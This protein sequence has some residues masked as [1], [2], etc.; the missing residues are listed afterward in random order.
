MTPG[1]MRK[2]ILEDSIPKTLLILSGPIIFN[3]LIQIIYNLVDTFW[4]GRLGRA[5]VS[6]PVVSWPIIFTVTMFGSGFATAGLALV[7]QYV[8]A[9]KWE[10]VDRTVGNL[11]SFLGML[12]L[13]FGLLGFIFAHQILMFLKI[14]NDVLPLASSYL[15]VIFISLPVVFVNFVFSMVLRAIGDTLTP[16]KVN[17]AS[18]LLNMILDPVLI[19]GYGFI[20]P[21]GVLGAAV[22]TVVSNAVASIIAVVILATGWKGIK[23]HLHDLIPDTDIISKIVKIGLPSA[24]G[25]SLN[26]LAFTTLMAI[27][28][29]F[30]SVATAAYGITMRVINI[31]SAV[32]FG[33]SQASAVM[34]GQ[35]I[36]AEQYTRTRKILW[37][38]IKMTF[39][40]MSVLAI[41]IFV[42]R[43][44]MVRIFISDPKVIRA[45]SEFIMYFS[46][47][48]PF[49]GIFFP[50]MQGLRAAGKTKRSALLSF[51]RLWLMRVPFAYTLSLA[52]GM[53][54]IWVGV[55]VANVLAGL[56]SLYY[57]FNTS[58]MKKII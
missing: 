7:S 28:G 22:A 53:T 20:P 45:G 26:G 23:V 25:N 40:I 36:G 11:L 55:S 33:L 51:V 12:S 15:S 1:K 10:R 48:V 2:R 42:S 58:W 32:A 54:G 17:V 52:F 41:L 24:I 27:V 30:G 57:V 43:D 47:S 31:I 21:L 18:L 9:N 35:N 13:V 49:F 14:P 8:G 44:A 38:T 56:V 5:A 6:A 29:T 34:I 50:I 37:D 39:G 19:F 46:L 4:L 3:Q 16:M